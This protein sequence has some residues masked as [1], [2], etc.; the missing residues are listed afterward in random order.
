MSDEEQS[1]SDTAQPQASQ[2]SQDAGDKTITGFTCN[3]KI[4][5]FWANDPPV[6]FAQ[7]EAQFKTKSIS[8]EGTKFAHV[9]SSLQ[10]EIATEVR[11]LIIDPP[12][13]NPYTRLKEALIKRTSVSEQKR[14]NQLLGGE[15]L[16]NRTPSQFLRRLQQLAG[17]KKLE[18]DIIKQLFLQRLPM[19]VQLILSSSSDKTDIEELAA[20]ADRIVEVAAPLTV[21]TMKSTQSAEPKT[22]PSSQSSPASSNVS[23]DV[24]RLTAQVAQL[25]AQVQ[26]LTTSMQRQRSRSRGR[27]RS[28]E[29][30]SRQNSPSPSPHQGEC[31]YHRRFGEKAHKCT[32]PCTYSSQSTNQENQQAGH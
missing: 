19:N 18:S 14:L 27:N 26:R 30:G 20:L 13:H 11:D 7:V 17:D 6:W 1:K 4:P 12:K 10:P 5:P 21:S 9:I 25:T 24:Q 22:S 32:K 8:A 23:D 3:I 31:W 15:E 16:G 28:S 2:D 29:S